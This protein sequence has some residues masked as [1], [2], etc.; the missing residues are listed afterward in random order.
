MFEAGKPESLLASIRAAPIAPYVDNKALVI[1]GTKKRL[2][3]PTAVK[4]LEEVRA[5]WH[6][7]N[8]CNSVVAECLG[9]GDVA[10]PGIKDYIAQRMHALLVVQ[11]KRHLDALEPVVRQ[12]VD[13]IV[14]KCPPRGK[15][16]PGHDDPAE[17]RAKP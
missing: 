14:R 5:Y 10:D 9:N 13:T 1:P 17:K 3:H 12:S 4:Q 16:K 15:R 11:L 7:H 6:L 2:K 8:A